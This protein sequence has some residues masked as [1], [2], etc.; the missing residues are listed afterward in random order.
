MKVPTVEYYKE[1]NRFREDYP[2]GSNYKAVGIHSV[3]SEDELRLFID[4]VISNNY[5]FPEI[6]DEFKKIK[7]TTIFL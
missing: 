3:S 4:S 7:N 6:I 5:R 2:N 1:A